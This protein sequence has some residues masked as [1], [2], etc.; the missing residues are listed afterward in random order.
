MRDR[1]PSAV[2]ALV[3]VLTLAALAV[4]AGCATIPTDGPVIEGNTGVDDDTGFGVLPA[5]PDPDEAPA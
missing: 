2:R 3:A 4:L 1:R 5:G